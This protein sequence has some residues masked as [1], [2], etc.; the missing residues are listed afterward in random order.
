MVY[1]N[2]T[3]SPPIQPSPGV[4]WTFVLSVDTFSILVSRLLFALIKLDKPSTLQRIHFSLYLRG[5]PSFPA[6]DLQSSIRC[7]Q[8]DM[9]IIISLGHCLLR[10]PNLLVS[11][12]SPVVL[13]CMRDEVF[14]VIECWNRVNCSAYNNIYSMFY[15]NYH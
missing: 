6:T 5:R 11:H 1:F 3:V 7:E 10:S 8:N 15:G 14:G 2:S 13:K 4:I 9:D 12:L